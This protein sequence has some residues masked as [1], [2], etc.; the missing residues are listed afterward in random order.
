[1]SSFAP[2][3][4]IRANLELDRGASPFLTVRLLHNMGNLAE[5]YGWFFFAAIS[6]ASGWGLLNAMVTRHLDH[7]ELFTYYIAQA[8]SIGQL[9]KLSHAVD[10]QPPLGYLLVRISFAVF[11]A[12]SWSCRL[13]FLLA[14][15]FTAA[16]LFHFVRRL[17]SP[18]YGLIATLLI[19]SNPYAM[20]TKA[21]PYA[22]LLCFT[23]LTLVA[24]YE[25]AGR[26][27]SIRGRTRLV[28]VILSGFGLL[29]SHVF[30]VLVYGAVM[31]AEIIRL[32]AR[33]KPDWRLWIALLIPLISVV[34]Y[35]PLLRNHSA[36]M[37]AEEYRV[38]PLALLSFYWE[39][40][41]F[42]ITPLAFMVLL[43]ILWPIFRKEQIGAPPRIP[44]AIRASLTFLLVCL[45]FLPFAIAI[46]LARTGTAF[47]NRYGIVWLVPFAV[48][49][50]LFL[51]YRTH[52]DRLAGTAAVLLLA[53]CFFFNTIGKSWFVEQVSNFVPANAAAKVLYAL[54][55]P[56]IVPVHFP[57][58]PSYLQTAFATAPFVS[59][60]ESVAPELPLVANTALTFLELDH[61][62]S[63]Q[64]AQRLYMLSDEEA[65][66]TIAHDTVFA[67]YEQVK[68]AFPMIRG[69]VEGYCSFIS[70][71]PR[72]VVVGA[73]NNPQGWLL[74]K[75]D[76]D[77]AQLRVIGTC[78]GNTED[79]QIYEI[80]LQSKQCVKPSQQ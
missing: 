53:V 7:D 12:S 8:P 27:G 60:L 38:T 21:R 23:S 35:L 25:A 26:D 28:I 6:L 11:G 40:V 63:P 61:Q 18:L 24:W 78:G 10:L 41:R 73:Y 65:A 33:R 57:P 66:S 79:C 16:L 4:P 59:H 69:K 3:Q 54:A 74:R 20:A 64:V 47:F 56:P 58:V 14:Y 34:T 29:L 55:F 44:I 37:F 42:L 50:A 75:L 9:V 51:G 30:G 13:P 22:I 17:L 62:E 48:V 1:M 5:R 43:G 70:A 36:M 19:W 32:W 39:S 80:S 77:G 76:Q 45:S 52:C 71:H 31:G 68:A 15:V 67:R 2:S 49:P 72:F 46:L